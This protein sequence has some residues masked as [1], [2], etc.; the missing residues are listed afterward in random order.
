MK[1]ILIIILLG[2]SFMTQAKEF[3]HVYLSVAGP[4]SGAGIMGHAFITFSELS[5]GFQKSETYQYAMDFNKIPE[6]LINMGEVTPGKILELAQAAND[7]P[8][9]IEQVPSRSFIRMYQDENRS[10]VVFRMK[11]TQEEISAIYKI[12]KADY[13]SFKRGELG[14]GDSF[15][16]RY[17]LVKSNCATVLLRKVGEVIGKTRPENNPFKTIYD[18]EGAFDWRE[19]SNKQALLGTLPLFWYSLYSESDLV[20][21]MRVFR[22]SEAEKLEI[23]SKLNGKLGNVLST[24][25]KSDL[26]STYTRILGDIE[27]R[28]KEPLIK[29]YVSTLEGCQASADRED[30]NELVALSIVMTRRADLFFSIF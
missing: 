16:D 10:I 28:Q 30:F 27:L 3:K 4:T 5:W 14:S 29:H 21:E 13:D 25:N 19:L 22:S 15:E 17:Y 1:T 23:M 18:S 11:F 26:R 2:L 9:S 20:E 7:L 6:H 24:C 8:I 12:I